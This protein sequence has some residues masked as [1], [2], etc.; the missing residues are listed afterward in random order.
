ME[1]QRKKKILS[2]C[3]LSLLAFFSFLLVKEETFAAT[4]TGPNGTV[5]TDDVNTIG[6]GG[7]LHDVTVTVN[8]GSFSACADLDGVNVGAWSATNGSTYGIA[9]YSGGA[10]IDGDHLKDGHWEVYRIVAGVGCVRADTLFF[11]GEFDTIGGLFAV[12]GSQITMDSPTEQTY[13]NNPITFS[14]DYDN[15]DTYDQVRFDLIF[16]DSM[17]ML[18]DPLNIPLINGT[19]LPWS[20]T[21]NLPYNGNYKVRVQ[22]YD[23]VNATSTEWSSYV[24]FGL[25]TT[26]VATSTLPGSPLQTVE[27]G[28]FDVLGFEF[29]DIACSI[30]QAIAWLLY[31]DVSVTEQFKSLSTTLEGKFPFAYAYQAP[32][33]VDTLFT[34]TQTASSTISVTVPNFGEI[35]FLSAA[36]LNSVPYAST[37]RTIIGW[38]LWILT[39][40]F[41]YYRTI[42][43]HDSNT[44]S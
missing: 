4:Y 27:C 7:V 33:L 34:S 19:D 40:E 35:T 44:P 38:L 41:F 37:V 26:T 24:S 25:G 17:N 23:S 28:S 12:P 29:P 16:N 36:L 18:F 5:F 21:R 11:A 2:L 15:L 42:R 3:L 39:I 30:K 1:I 43:S 10:A 6:G 14:G 9:D 8:W 13:L 31:P 20:T 32:D 22:L